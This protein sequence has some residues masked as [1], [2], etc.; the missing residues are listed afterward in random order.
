MCFPTKAATLRTDNSFRLRTD[1]EHHTKH[2]IIENLINFDT[3]LDFPI[4]DPLHLLHIG[5]A[6]KMLNRWL[7]GTKTYKKIFSKTMLLQF[8]ELLRAVNQ[9]KPKEINRQIRTTKD[10]ARWKATEHRT[11]LLYAGIVI[12]KRFIPHQEYELFLCLCVAVKLASVDRYLKDNNRIILIKDLLENF[13]KVYSKIYGKHTISSNVH[14]LCHVSADLERF[15]NIDSVSTYPFENHLGKI[16]HKIR[17]YRN[18]LQQFAK[19]VG[20]LEQVQSTIDIKAPAKSRVELKFPERP[21]SQSYQTILL[22]EYQLSSRNVADSWFLLKSADKIIKFEKVVQVDNN[23][24]HNAL[25]HG[26]EI[27]DMNSFFENPFDSKYIDIYISNCME[28]N[29]IVCSVDDIKCKLLRIPY[30]E[31]YVF[32]PLLHTL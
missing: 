15:G 19:R 32:Q 4:C 8:D 3:V 6:K 26:K 23:T 31:K 11:L 30:D 12:L 13:V 10:F 9:N 7:N 27:T 1:P 18:P 2:S 20:E 29:S 22:N 17:A 16:K 28:K 14:Y 5:L 25:I 21:K 24:V